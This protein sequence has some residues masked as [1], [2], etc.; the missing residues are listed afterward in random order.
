MNSFQ[1]AMTGDLMKVM[2]ACEQYVKIKPDHDNGL[3]RYLRGVIDAPYEF[4]GEY[5]KELSGSHIDSYV[6]PT[7]GYNEVRAAFASQLAADIR[8]FLK[9]PDAAPEAPPKKKGQSINLKKASLQRIFEFGLRHGREQAGVCLSNGACRM[10]GDNGFKCI[11]GAMIEDRL[12][13]ICDDPDS[14]VPSCPDQDSDEWFA[15]IGKNESKYRLLSALQRAHD[16]TVGQDFL[17]DFEDRMQKVATEFNLIYKPPGSS[18][19]A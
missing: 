10:R 1:H 16:R 11:V 17:P 4:I 5:R 19:R 7:P 14:N 9:L 15:L 13:A 3:C 8:K 18:L 12:A 6:S 2:D